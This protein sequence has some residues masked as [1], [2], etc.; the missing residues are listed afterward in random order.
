MK[1]F[2]VRH[3]ETGGNVAH[4]HQAEHTPL[5]K[6]GEAQV[7]QAASVIKQLEPTH[8]LSSPLVRTIE[9]AR[10][11]GNA[12]DLIPELNGHFVELKR[13]PKLHGHHMKSFRSL[14]YY[15]EWYFGLKNPF[16]PDGE[17]YKML[18]ARIAEAQAHLDSY[19]DD[20]RVVVVSHSVFINLFLVHMCSRRALTPLGAVRAFWRVLTMP[21]TK[22][23]PIAYNKMAPSGTCAWSL[24][25]ELASL[26]NS[27]SISA[28]QKEG[29]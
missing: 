28:D 1:I 29:K 16:L 11:I 21:N 12:C 22:V 3:G 4:R 27:G 23:T 5:T 25:K 26:I 6:R 14:A 19:P 7:A 13:P 20:A 24:D 17:S 8:L 9:T 18:R 15:A 10:V 2:L